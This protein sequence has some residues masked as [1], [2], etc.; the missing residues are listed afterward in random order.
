[1]LFGSGKEMIVIEIGT[2]KTK[3]IVG[4]N[5]GQK[6]KKGRVNDVL[7]IREAFS[8]DTPKKDQVD[9]GF[10]VEAGKVFQPNFDDEKAE[11]SID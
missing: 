2:E 7:R 9:E 11:E 6:R 8:F 1:M 4:R 5:M 3:V 10:E